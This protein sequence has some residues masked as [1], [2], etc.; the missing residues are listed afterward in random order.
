MPFDG[1]SPWA[2]WR[3]WPPRRRASTSM[4]SP[5][6]VLSTLQGHMHAALSNAR[7]YD[8][9]RRQVVT[10]HLTRLYN[11]RFFMNRADEEL[12]R[13]LRNQQPLS[14]VMLDIDHFKHSTTPTATPPA[15]ACCRW[16]PRVMQQHVRKSDICSRHGGEEFAMLLPN[17]P[18]DNARLHGQP[19]ASHAGR[20]TL[21]RPRAAQRREHHD[22]HRGRDLPSRRD[23]RRPS[24]SS[25]PTRRSTRP[26]PAAATAS[27][28]TASRCSRSS[29]TRRAAKPRTPERQR[30]S[31]STD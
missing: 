5:T 28:S 14:L 12:A 1:R 20:D 2:T 19:P 29:T 11:R 15:T 23:D 7:K 17:T 31:R 4:R 6:N 24:S 27:C 16:S 21:H 25:W 30:R 26:R 10:D 9:I 18:G 3:C 13:S 22:Q 8:S